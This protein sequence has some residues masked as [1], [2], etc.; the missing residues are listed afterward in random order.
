VLLQKILNSPDPL[1]QLEFELRISPSLLQ[2]MT[3]SESLR[4]LISVIE[5]R[6]KRC[7]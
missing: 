5:D 7:L 3:N 4:Q 2:A 6:L 1:I